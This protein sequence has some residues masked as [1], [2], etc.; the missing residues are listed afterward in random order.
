[1]FRTVS[2]CLAVLGAVTFFSFPAQAQVNIPMYETVHQEIAAAKA[3]A[4]RAIK[5]CDEESY[6][7]A[8]DWLDEIAEDAP[9]AAEARKIDDL[10][11]GLDTTW[12]ITYPCGEN[13]RINPYSLTLAGSYGGFRLKDGPVFLGKENGGVINT[14]G[15]VQPDR[16]GRISGFDIGLRMPFGR[17]FHNLYN[18]PNNTRNKPG[19]FSNLWKFV[20]NYSYKRSDLNESFGDIGTGGDALLLPGVGS[21]PNGAGFSLPFAGGLNTVTMAR[22]DSE[23]RW[24]S[25]SAG[26]EKNVKRNNVNYRWYGGLEY[27]HLDARQTFSG[28]IPG[29]ARDFRYDSLVD[30]YTASPYA[31][32][33]IG[34]TPEWLKNSKIP[35]AE[36]Y[37]GMKYNLGYSWADGTDSLAFTGFNT[38]SIDLDEKGLTH[39]LG[40]NTGMKFEIDRGME[41]AFDV[42]FETEGNNP[43]IT[44][45][46]VGPSNLSFERSYV[47]R[48][49]LGVR[50]TF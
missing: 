42:S 49:G 26:G 22:Y 28:E 25:L 23:Y 44:R 45:D 37:G 50:F 31:G 19:T 15:F 13:P 16:S 38:Q 14:L 2:T 48:I 24:N 5:N 46:G 33:E 12:N 39:G 4:A 17:A 30:V 7:E 43:V 47:G 32:I 35:K 3:Q 20:F 10:I 9:S 34:F 40:I 41:A 8:I 29:F 18:L 6:E 1:M 36:L 21:G 27:G 11:D